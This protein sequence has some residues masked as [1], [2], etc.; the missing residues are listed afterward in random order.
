MGSHCMCLRTGVNELAIVC[1]IDRLTG[2]SR[3]KDRRWSHI[4]C[5][6]MLLT[7]HWLSSTSGSYM[8]LGY[9]SHHPWPLVKLA[10][11]GGSCSPSSGDQSMTPP[12]Q[13]AWSPA[14]CSIVENSGGEKEE[15]E[16]PP[17]ACSL[18]FCPTNKQVEAVKM[19][20]NRSQWQWLE[21]GA[22]NGLFT[23]S[24]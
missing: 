12:L 8:M 19:K 23:N 3:Q 21:P 15:Q 17:P 13:P 2:A 6:A 18:D 7:L 20:R 11:D 16:V 10:V 1:P 14:S 5:K 22:S 4:E 9:N 24:V